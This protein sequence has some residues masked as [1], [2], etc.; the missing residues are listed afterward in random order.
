[1]QSNCSNNNNFACQSFS[2]FSLFSSSSVFYFIVSC[3]FVLFFPLGLFSFSVFLYVF[4]FGSFFFFYS[5]FLEIFVP[6][7]FL[8]LLFFYYFF[9]ALNL[10]CV[11]LFSHL[12]NSLQFHSSNYNLFSF[13][14]F[15]SF[16]FLSLHCSLFFIYIPDRVF[17]KQVI[18]HIQTNHDLSSVLFNARLH[19]ML[20]TL[21]IRE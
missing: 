12:F 5:Y 21:K 6:L 13:F 19:P 15:P 18:L 2:L 20:P 8:L 7:L 4:L 14:L 3:F 10:S 17:N 16:I 11:V 1:M 9:L